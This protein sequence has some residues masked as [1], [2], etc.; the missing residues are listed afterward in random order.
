MTDMVGLD[1]YDANTRE[2]F[3]LLMKT[4]RRDAGLTQEDVAE[5]M[6]TTRAY[7]SKIEGWKRR[8]DINLGVLQRYARSIG[9]RV[10][11]ELEPVE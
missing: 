9:Y 5:I 2:D 1:P 8:R 10:V 7:V 6:N 3:L 11:L 4:L